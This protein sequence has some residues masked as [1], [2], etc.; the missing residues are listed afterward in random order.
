MVAHAQSAND[1]A[2]C[3]SGT[4][5]PFEI[6]GAW[7]YITASGIAIPPKFR[8]ATPFSEGIAT[9]CLSDGCGLIDLEGRLLTPLQ[10]SHIMNLA[11]RYSEGVGAVV[12][13]NNWGYSDRSG[14]IVIPFQFEYAGAFDKGIARVRLHGK[15]FFINH[16]GERITPEFDGLFDFSEDLA[17]AL[18][19]DKVGY[20]RRDGLF[21]LPPKYH[22]ASGIDFSEGLV[23]VRIDGRVGFMDKSGSIVV[24][25]SYTDAYP[26]LRGPCACS[27][28]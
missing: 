11:S 26:F 5:I 27:G 14:N 8:T 12:K 19:G 24:R 20:I 3:D 4:P 23:A 28:K 13:G 10:G 16:K 25:P 22:G 15:Y 7:G 18:V 1:G 21:A 17:A 2:T 6:G 9:V